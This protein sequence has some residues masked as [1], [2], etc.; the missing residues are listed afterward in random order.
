M[1]PAVV[2]AW[3]NV[4]EGGLGRARAPSGWEH[5]VDVNVAGTLYD[6]G[7]DTAAQQ[8]TC[9]A[10][11]RDADDDLGGVDAAGELQQ[12]FRDVVADDGVVA[13]AQI[14]DEPALGRQRFAILPSAAL[15][16]GA[17]ER[18]AGRRR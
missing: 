13:A 4:P 15:R 12:G 14:C 6:L 17:R 2:R 18:P 1:N 8:T 7:A 11:A 10:A 3:P 16:D 5:H 9:E